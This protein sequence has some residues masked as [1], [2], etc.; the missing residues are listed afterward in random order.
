MQ[1]Q[2]EIVGG[3]ER[4]SRSRKNPHTLFAVLK[5]PAQLA[6]GY[7]VRAQHSGG[8]WGYTAGT[9]GDTAVSGW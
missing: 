5:A 4:S 8:S 9:Q 6:S 7:I 3:D 1:T 2:R